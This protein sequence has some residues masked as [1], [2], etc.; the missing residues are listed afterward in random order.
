[1]N[2]FCKT[3]ALSVL[4]FSLVVGCEFDGNRAH[5][6]TELTDA[7]AEAASVQKDVFGVDT[8]LN[9][10]THVI[11]R[12]ESL[13][14]ILGSR[15]FSGAQINAL[16]H[17]SSGI[18]DVRRI[19][20][21]RPLHLYT[22]A[23]PSGDHQ[24]ITTLVYEESRT[25]FV[26]FE[27][28]DS[29]AV[30]RD[31]RAIETRPRMVQGE[32]K[33]SLYEALRELDVDR[34][35]TMRLADVFAWQ[36]DFY[37]IQRGDHF[38]VLFEEQFI[39]DERVGVGRIKAALFNHRNED[40][41]AFHYVQNGINEY[42]DEYGNSMRR[43]FMAAP[44]DYT[45]ISSRFS[46]SRFHPV[47]GRH[48]PHHGTDYAAPVGTPIRAVGDGVITTARYDRNNGNYVRIRH[49]SIYETGYLHM[50]RFADGIKSGVQVQQGQIIGYVGATGLATGP[51]LCFRFWQHGR[52]VDPHRIDLPPADPIHPEHL[53]TFA[54]R[55]NR[56]IEEMGLQDR[57]SLEPPI[58]FAGNIGYSGFLNSLAPPVQG[59]EL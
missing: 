15:G 53:L 55:R 46:H 9:M 49:N 14:Q 39:D 25:D 47:L 34:Q 28:G 54:E 50:S 52:P 31:I 59:T 26:R 48:M 2:R 11:R 13:S 32:I 3:L 29:I 6:E 10:E 16:S 36:V 22:A 19:R 40:Y 33:S 21:G 57:L 4:F 42:F 43:Q 8:S 17:A 56:F 45:R 58:Q 7:I 23:N 18:F 37:R 20:A 44:L 12:N 27:M 1:M 24:T 5:S 30:V 51:H 38:Q 35:L 41:Y